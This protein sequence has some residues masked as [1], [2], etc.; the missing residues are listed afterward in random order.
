MKVVQ[1]EK[2]MTSPV[3]E[4]LKPPKDKLCITTQK[5]HFI[6]PKKEI[7][8]L[9]ADGNYTAIYYKNQKLLCSKTIQSV[10]DRI[11]LLSFFRTHKSFVINSDKV[12]FVDPSFSYAVTINDYKIP[13]AKSKKQDFKHFINSK[14]D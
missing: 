14:F 5:G 10:F 12:T 13:V 3:I 6:I 7:S 9:V 11:N 1:L 2:A 8:H 4:S